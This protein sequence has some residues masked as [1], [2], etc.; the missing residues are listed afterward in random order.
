MG[1]KND[2]VQSY[3]PEWLLGK[4]IDIFIPNLNV[5]IEFNGSAFHHSSKTENLNSFLRSVSKDPSYHHEKW[6]ACFENGVT[7]ISVYDFYW[8]D[9]LKKE[10]Y[11]SKFKHALGL[12]TK[13]Y[14]RKCIIKEI[15]NSESKQ[16]FEDNHI[17]G[18]GFNY[19]DLKSFGMYHNN[20]LVMCASIGDIYNQSS[21]SWDKKLQRICTLQGNT[22]VGGISKLTSYLLK[23]VGNFK[24][25]ITLDSGGTSL[26]EYKTDLSKVTL[27]YFW[28]DPVSFKFHSRNYCQKSVLEKHFEMKLEPEDTENNYMERLGYLKV[29]DSGIAELQINKKNI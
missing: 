13:I 24:Y 6:K 1:Y 25:Q 29:Y 18:P 8:K 2:I 21:K 5:A 15:S 20:D 4:E 3:R 16:F 11:K 26:K 17:E 14:A 23:T 10:I 22:V 27:R 28:V 7:L 9:P 12:D 19:K